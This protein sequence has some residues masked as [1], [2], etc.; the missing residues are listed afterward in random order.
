MGKQLRN[1]DKDKKKY[2]NSKV[3]DLAVHAEKLYLEKVIIQLEVTE[4]TFTSL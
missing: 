3:K 1:E 4:E 2:E